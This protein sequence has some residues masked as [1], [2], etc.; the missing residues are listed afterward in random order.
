[1]K[2]LLLFLW[3]I[4]MTITGIHATTGCHACGGLFV[5]GLVVGIR[6]V[7]WSDAEDL[8]DEFNQSWDKIEK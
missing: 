5:L 7:N 3:F 2:N 1:M 4:G 8:V 6:F